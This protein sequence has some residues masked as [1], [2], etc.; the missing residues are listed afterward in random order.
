MTGAAGPSGP[1][2]VRPG[3]GRIRRALARAGHPERGFRA[4]H[5]AGTNGKG[6]TACFIETMLRVLSDRRVGLFTSPHL[7]SP[8]ERIRIDGR[9]IPKG[10]LRAGFRSA[11]DPLTYFERMTWVA[12]D[13]FRRKK[14]GIAVMETGLGGRWDATNACRSSV[15]VITTV[16]YDHMEWLGGTL[17]RIAAEKAGILRK[18]IPLVVGR[19]RPA[20]RSVVLRRARRL[21]CSTW[22]MGRD[23]DWEENGE[24]AIRVILPG[25][26]IDDVRPALTGR[27]Q[28]DNAAIALAAAWRWA[29]IEGICR[30]RF[31]EVAKRAV[32][33]ARWPGRFCRLPLRRN[34]GAWVDGGHNPEAARAV[35]REIRE[36]PPWG[37]GKRI[38]AL[39]SM[40]ADKDAAGYLRELSCVLAA[41]VVYPMSHERASDAGAL[42]RRCEDAGIRHV[43]AGGFREGWV[44][45]RRLAGPGGV[46]LV[47][48]SLVAVGEAYRHR[49]GMVP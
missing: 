46:V 11:G 20:A 18:G 12:C 9:K 48:G 10:C 7:I 32:R 44:L 39:W 5:I 28:W 37:K 42:A 8:E 16:G 45:A 40:L 24:G 14:V 22:E 36:S 29:A 1:E 19:L 23:F 33:E 21:G 43:V 13:W 31:A 49:V 30:S 4:I 15:S 3:L 2:A 47:C 41:A 34:A 6:S 27:F 26:R 25:L 38:V 35:A 17:G